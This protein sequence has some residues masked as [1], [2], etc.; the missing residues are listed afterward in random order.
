MLLSQH[1]M[2]QLIIG[3]GDEII[4]KCN[5]PNTP[6]KRAYRGSDQ[7]W[8]VEGR[9]FSGSLAQVIGKSVNISSSKQQQSKGWDTPPG[10]RLR[11]NNARGSRLEQ[12]ISQKIQ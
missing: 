9:D 12:L 11:G 3:L 7:W 4:P 2:C 8:E 10:G 6:Y 5:A 1:T